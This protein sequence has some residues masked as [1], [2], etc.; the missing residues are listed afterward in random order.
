MSKKE[1]AKLVVFVVFCALLSDFL[2]NIIRQPKIA[3]TATTTPVTTATATSTATATT[4][5]TATPTRFPTFVPTLE[6]TQ[7][8]APIGN[9]WK[10]LYEFSGGPNVYV[11]ASCYVRDLVDCIGQTVE[12][13]LQ[14]EQHNDVYLNGFNNV[15]DYS[16]L[17]SIRLVPGHNQLTIP[18][19]EDVSIGNMTNIDVIE[20]ASK[21][22]YLSCDTNE[23]GECVCVQYDDATM[24]YQ[25]PAGD[26]LYLTTI[27]FWS[28]YS[29][30]FFLNDMAK[31][32]SIAIESG[33]I[34]VL[35]EYDYE[36]WD[37]SVL[38]FY[39]ERPTP[40][41]SRTPQP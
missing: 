19:A 4:I 34:L 16:Q 21:G 39:G 22:Y 6:P 9:G 25:S 24:I 5:P 14:G 8:P 1:L 13:Y 11:K 36:A 2:W 30:V 33:T 41:P 29:N 35:P 23:F 17:W 20:F 40:M 37:L 12:V 15:Q 27:E 32:I 28:E 10:P 3:A 18:V 7:V 38:P 26:G 31:E